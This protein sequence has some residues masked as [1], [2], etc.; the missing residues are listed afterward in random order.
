MIE[1]KENLT[2]TE[3]LTASR[4]LTKVDLSDVYVLRYKDRGLIAETHFILKSTG[5]AR[6]N[7]QTAIKRAQDFCDRTRFR[8]IHCEPFL[9]DLEEMEKRMAI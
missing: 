4:S 9:T 6:Q 8:F 5:D 2:A 7:K 3:A 1:T